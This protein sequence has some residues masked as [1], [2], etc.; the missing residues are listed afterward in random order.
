MLNFAPLNDL[1]INAE[2]QARAAANI[3][4]PELVNKILNSINVLLEDA[5]TPT[6]TTT[7]PSPPGIFFETIRNGERCNNINGRRELLRHA[8]ADRGDRPEPVHAQQ[9]CVNLLHSFL[10]SPLF[11]PIL[12]RENAPAVG[13]LT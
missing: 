3:T 1:Q 13:A 4:R 2:E 8:R 5:D 9:K 6:S 12:H 11:N 7:V 10:S